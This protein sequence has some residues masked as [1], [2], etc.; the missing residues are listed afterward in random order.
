MKNWYQ[1]SLDIPIEG[2]DTSREYPRPV[3]K[4]I[5]EFQGAWKSEGSPADVAL[6]MGEYRGF[7]R[8]VFFFPPTT[9]SFLSGL[10]EAY[11]A[12]RIEEPEP[13][14]L[15]KKIAGSDD[16]FAFWLPWVDL[17]SI[18]YPPLRSGTF[19]S[20]ADPD[21]TSQDIETD[22]PQTGVFSADRDEPDVDAAIE[23]M[24]SGKFASALPI[25]IEATRLFPKEYGYWHMA[26]QCYRFVEDLPNA[27]KF[28][29]EA[30]RLDR[31]EKGAFL[32]LGI[33]FQIYGQFH[34]AI[35]AF[36]KALEI[37]PNYDLAFNSLALT[38]MKKGDYEY[39]LH[40]YDEA[41]KAMTRRLVSSFTNSPSRGITKHH[42][43]P[44][45]LWGE[46]AI[47][48]AMFLA[49]SDDSI[50][51]LAWPTGEFAIREEKD[52]GFEGLY[53][54]DQ[55]NSSGR[56]TRLFLPNYFNTFEARLRDNA[57]YSMFLR[58]KGTAL[59][60]LGRNAEAQQHFDESDYFRPIR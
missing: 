41:L 7:T 3:Q 50:E 44:F 42:D 33:A 53:W 34:N 52:E 21:A 17:D 60:A 37:D 40:N 11:G 22:N 55:I 23:L 25:M 15:L 43:S 24:K 54:N 36:T 9:C 31:T 30:A 56:K 29:K 4:L 35:G 13:Y 6:F 51:E 45:S 39:A 1:I 47:F 26:G 57:D 14:R 49:S 16:A 2:P 27:I 32:A 46:Y 8:Q 5:D 20:I 12:Y 59:E 19:R 28:L 10:L 58:A 38:Q 18:E 48:G